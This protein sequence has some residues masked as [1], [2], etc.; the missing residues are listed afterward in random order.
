MPPVRRRRLHRLS[1]R[2]PKGAVG[3]LLALVAVGASWF[4]LAPAPLG[5]S[6]SFAII[7]GTSMLPGLRRD[8]LVLVRPAASYRVGDVVAYRSRLI[9]RIVLHRIVAVRG[10]RYSFKGDNNRFL[11]PERVARADLVGKRW[12]RLPA[13]GRGATAVHVPWVAAVLAA[14]LVIAWGAGGTDE[15]GGPRPE[16]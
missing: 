5:G 4:F 8:D 15:R 13:A 2:P 9:H 7:D 6:T 14:L 16:R 1:R 11:D 12:L 3:V 10:N